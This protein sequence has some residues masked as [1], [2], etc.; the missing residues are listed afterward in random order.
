MN[1]SDVKAH[2][3]TVAADGA[4]KKKL[5]PEMKAEDPILALRARTSARSKVEKN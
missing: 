5:H 1:C 2:R 4:R 3:C